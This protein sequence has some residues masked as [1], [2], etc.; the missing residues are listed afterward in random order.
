MTVIRPRWDVIQ[1]TARTPHTS[2]D[3]GSYRLQL[4]LV[5]HNRVHRAGLFLGPLNKKGV[6]LELLVALDGAGGV[7]V[8]LGVVGSAWRMGEI[9]NY[10]STMSP[11]YS[12][13]IGL[14]GLR[15][16]AAYR[17]TIN[18]GYR[19]RPRRFQVTPL[20]LSK[21]K[22]RPRNLSPSWYIGARCRLYFAAVVGVGGLHLLHSGDWWGV[23]FY[24]PLFKGHALR[25]PLIRSPLCSR[26]LGSN[27]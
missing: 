8:E 19:G 14:R 16:T 10:K 23:T 21:K 15:M 17:H 22:G 18:E 6:I 24:N 1:R 26:P 13:G 2:P 9:M 27:T 4:Q 20:I 12:G 5:V 3:P 11:V 7:V 25:S